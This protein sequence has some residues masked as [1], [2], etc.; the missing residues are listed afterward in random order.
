MEKI[1]F[2]ERTMKIVWKNSGIVLLSVVVLLLVTT[3]TTYAKWEIEYSD[4][5]INAMRRAGAPIEKR[6][7]NFATRNECQQA[8]EDAVRR[9]GDYTLRNNM[10]CVGSDDP[11]PSQRHP[12]RTPQGKL[13]QQTYLGQSEDDKQR[14]EQE[15]AEKEKAEAFEREKEKLLKAFKGGTSTGITVP[16]IGTTGLPLKGSGSSQTTGSKPQDLTLKGGTTPQTGTTGL[17]LKGAGDT[18]PTISKSYDPAIKEKTVKAIKQL[19]C[20]AYWALNAVSAAEK[21]DYEMARR[22]GE[23]SAQAKGGNTASGCPEVKVYVPDVPP[24]LEANPQI[25]LYNHIL[26]QAGVLAVDIIETRQKI[27]KAN[28]RLENTKKDINVKQEKIKEIDRLLNHPRGKKEV[29]SVQKEKTEKELD[30][31]T[32][33]AMA[34]EKDAAQLKKTADEHPGKLSDLQGMY[35][36]VTE[37]PQRAEELTKK[38]R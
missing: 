5:L 1:C 27:E 14:A 20:S 23:F 2:T 32:K 3:A 11:T 4:G 37:N 26:Q 33:M 38:V 9:S 18:K 35:Q 16:D 34:L 21:D 19:N 28:S 29:L 6:V 22:Y 15:K 10:T 36:F 31:L 13:S 12:G 25:R 24:P 7:G 30:E 17:P 8:L